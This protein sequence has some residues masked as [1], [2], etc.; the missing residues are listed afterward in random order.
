ML[1]SSRKYFSRAGYSSHEVGF[2]LMASFVSGFIGIQIVSRFV[3]QLIPTHVV[4][5]DH[6]HTDHTTSHSHFGHGYHHSEPS[7]CDPDQ[8]APLKS[9]S[10]SVLS[11]DGVANEFTPLLGQALSPRP[12]ESRSVSSHSR[13]SLACEEQAGSLEA[14][15]PE[16]RPILLTGSVMSFVKDTKTNCDES[17]PCYG[18]TDLCGQE[19]YKH[20]NSQPIL[21]TTTG[22]AVTS[23]GIWNGDE[24][25]N[26]RT[27][28]LPTTEARIHEIRTETASLQ[29]GG[30]LEN[31]GCSSTID[32]ESQSQHQ[33]HVPKNAF[34][35]IGLQTAI[36]IAL[37]K[38][39]EGFITWAS[40]HANPDLGFNV[41]MALF[42][43]N[44]AEGFALAIPLYMTVGN[45][46]QAIFWSFV[47]GGLSQP[48]GA[49][50]A[51]LWFRATHKTPLQ[52]NNTV[53]AAL[54][55]ITAGI[56]VS[57]GMNL[58]V[59][60]LSMN[61]NRTLTIGF[62]FLGMVILGCSNALVSG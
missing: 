62:A 44:I 37:H 5:C 53:Y 16:R 43:H 57:V 11:V 26:I 34:L 46:L 40:N 13:C 39:P 47:L 18:Y 10:A 1:P 30:R 4:D 38:L 54:F 56:M 48:A 2:L 41:F 29:H 19:C 49:F 35:S 24:T 28:C 23:R 27:A 45:R 31:D 55:G 3:H 7:S 6:T 36:A 25:A 61:H 52:P 9:G 42:T 22:T 33:H 51:V 58:F 14:P 21:R 15:Q 32:A 20:L 59:E 60:S 12:V 50:V 8:S 17:G